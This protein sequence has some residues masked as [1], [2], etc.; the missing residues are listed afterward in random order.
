MTNR[1]LLAA[2]AFA[3]LM[4]APVA[5]AAPAQANL[6]L[7]KPFVSS[8]PNDAGWNQGLTDGSWLFD[9][10][11]TFA[12]GGSDSFPKTVTIDLKAPALLGYVGTAVP[13]FGSTKTVELS[14]SADGT[15]YTKAGSYVFSQNKAEYHLF[16][17]A[18]STAQYIRL[19]YADRYPDSVG[20]PS[21]FVFT[22]EVTAYAP[23][24]VPPVPQI[25]PEPPDAAAPKFGSDGQIDP[26]FQESH[27]SFLKRGKEGPIGVLFIGDSITHRWLGVQD[28]W[29][30]Y[31]G[32]YDP[33][34]F[35]IEGDRTEHVLW[36][37]ANGEL[38]GI[39]PKVVVL[40]IGTNNIALAAEDIIKGDTAVVSEI[41]RRLPDAKVLLMGIFPRGADAS[42][43]ARAKIKDVNAALAKLD[44][45]TK[46]R[47]LDIGNKLLAPDGSITKEIMPDALHPTA[48]GY[49]IWADAMQPLL[50][51][52]MKP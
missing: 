42:D 25:G 27:E 5:F 6:A 2:V 51:E 50:E 19:T 39:H 22:T 4:P 11:K 37:F 48:Q 28:I 13:Q 9:A 38:D 24:D 21:V 20:Y 23:G 10:G 47:F 33:A 35:G 45:G 52:M 17:F 18:P 15:Q 41:H 26:S 14:L 7:H 34:D 40:L 46:T 8:D 30:K 43:P 31:Y 32:Q 29:Q 49:Q 44:D 16:R 3:S 1:M 12:M 36:R